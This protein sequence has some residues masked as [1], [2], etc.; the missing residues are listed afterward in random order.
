MRGIPNYPAAQADVV[1]YR[2]HSDVFEVIAALVSAAP[3]L[4]DGNATERLT[5]V[6]ATPELFDVLGVQ[7]ELG[8]GF[9]AEDGLP[10]SEDDTAAASQP[11]VLSNGFWRRRFGADPDI[12]GR[13]LRFGT[14]SAMVVGVMPEDFRILLPP[15]DGI[16]ETPDV[17]V[18]FAIDRTAPRGPFFLRTAGRLAPGVALAAARAQMEAVSG[19]QQAQYPSAKAAGTTVRLVPLREDVSAGVRPVLLSMGAAVAFV[20]LIACVNVAN[21]L[22]VRAAGR[23]RELSVR[24]ALGGG[25]RKSVV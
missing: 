12:L 4:T 2:A 10:P 18:P 3:I 23:G 14:E 16:P 9:T 7:P 17:I 21:L 11:V 25:D 5:A 13:T 15:D 24:R 8:R 20:L 22:L 6:A 1:D 19:Y